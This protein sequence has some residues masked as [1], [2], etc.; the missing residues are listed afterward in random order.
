MIKT[1]K[2]SNLVNFGVLTAATRLIRTLSDK[3]AAANEVLLLFVYNYKSILAIVD[4]YIVGIS[5]NTR[6]LVNTA[7]NNNLSQKQNPYID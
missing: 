1:G 5:I 2:K 7:K 6:P 3:D 4:F